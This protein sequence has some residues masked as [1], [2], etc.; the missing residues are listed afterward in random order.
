VRSR[1]RKVANGDR[2][3]PLRLSRCIAVRRWISQAIGNGTSRRL[4]T[5]RS[6]LSPIVAPHTPPQT[7]ERPRVRSCR[8]PHLRS[9]ARPA[10][11]GRERRSVLCRPC[12]VRP[13]GCDSLRRKHGAA[14]VKIDHCQG[15]LRP[16]WRFQLL[17]VAGKELKNRRF[18]FVEKIES[19]RLLHKFVAI[20]NCLRHADC[21]QRTLRGEGFWIGTGVSN[22][23]RPS[24]ADKIAL[25]HSIFAGRAPKRCR[26]TI[27]RGFPEICPLGNEPPACGLQL[28]YVTGWL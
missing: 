16:I 2:R 12:P 4:K 6:T 23:G 22:A 21:F 28:T 14:M 8:I 25:L 1:N 26:L 13:H 19:K 7:S 17:S 20:P 11:G 5:L 3:A 18:D 10:S 24:Q 27:R 15:A 9:L